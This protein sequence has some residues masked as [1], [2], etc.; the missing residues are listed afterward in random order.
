MTPSTFL[1]LNLAVA[2]YNVGTIW[3]HE[4]DI[5]RTW[6]LVDPKDFHRI[7]RVHWRK[8]PYW[9]FAP[10]GLALI[11]SIVLFWYHPAAMPLSLTWTAFVSLLAS[12]VLTG[13]F[14]G[15]WQAQLSRDERASASPHLSQIL[16]THWIRTAL[17]NAYAVAL[18]GGA[19]R[20][21]G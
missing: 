12:Y 7:Q 3:A 15:R 16:A 1:L 6:R 10:V 2:F 18:L 11:G 5:F 17:I 8:L 4:I 20:V 14:W 21:W 19:V 9:I 13:A